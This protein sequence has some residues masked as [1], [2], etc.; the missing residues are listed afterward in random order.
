MIEVPLTRGLVAIIDAADADLIL[1]MGKWFAHVSPRSSYALRNVTRPDGSRRR[2]GM[3]NV[4][5]GWPMVDHINGDGLDCRR[6][7]MRAASRAQNNRNAQR[8]T[9]NTSGYKGVSWHGQ[10]NRWRAQINNAGRRTYLG[11]FADPADAARAY[12]TAARQHFGEFAC[13]NFPETTS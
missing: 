4:I 13:L 2:I 1:G 9:D 12:D 6:A 8:R 7:N 10:R 3:H 11:L 5:T